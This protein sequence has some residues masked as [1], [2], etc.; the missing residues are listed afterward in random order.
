MSQICDPF[1]LSTLYPKYQL[2]GL[3]FILQCAQTLFVLNE[4]HVHSFYIKV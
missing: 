2:S 4:H 3:G 1:K